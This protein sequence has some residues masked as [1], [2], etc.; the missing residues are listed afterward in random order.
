[1]RYNNF[2]TGAAD[3]IEKVS[4][5]VEMYFTTWGMS[6]DIGALN[7]KYMGVIGENISNK[8]FS[9]CKNMVDLLEEF[10]IT[11]LTNNKKYVK[12]IAKSLLKNETIVYKEIKKILP[13]KLENSLDV[14]IDKM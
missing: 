7:P 9:K 14:D 8:I 10:T 6:K 11:Q 5:L 3:D 4:H 1:M 12:K 13:D 2:S